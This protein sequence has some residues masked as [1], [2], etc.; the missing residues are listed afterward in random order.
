MIGTV[1]QKGHC[2]PCVV[3]NRSQSRPCVTRLCLRTRRCVLL[4]R[5]GEDNGSAATQ[6]AT[7]EQLESIKVNL[8]AFPEVQFFRVEAIVR[9][10]RLAFV[11]EQLSKEGIRG[12]TNTPV[13]GVG[14]QGGFRERYA[15]TE[16]ARTDLV[17][18]EKI[19]VVVSRSQVDIVTRIIAAAAYTGEIGDGKIFVHPVA[20]VV[21]VRT[22]ETGAVAERMQGGMSDQQSLAGKPEASG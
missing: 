14:M 5:A 20:D 3:A 11:I 21:R 9:P 12:L 18:K 17:V 6:R 15:G 2:R 4:V 16:F 19:D 13:K 10:W 1:L 8:A 22:A 7:Y